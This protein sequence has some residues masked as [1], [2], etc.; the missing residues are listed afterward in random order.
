MKKKVEKTY[1]IKYVKD[2]FQILFELT[3]LEIGFQYIPRFITEEVY[4]TV[5]K[6]LLQRASSITDNPSLKEESELTYIRFKDTYRRDTQREGIFQILEDT[7]VKLDG[8]LLKSLYSVYYPATEDNRIAILGE[9][10]VE[11][12]YE[13]N[14]SYGFE[15]EVVTFNL[16]VGI[17]VKVTKEGFFYKINYEFNW[18][19]KK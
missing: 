11:R 9:Y 7:Y 13:E 16:T 8:P 19:I 12:V 3:D 1:S 14:L 18:R 10:S 6:S 5:T 4:N 2:G 17:E 15:K